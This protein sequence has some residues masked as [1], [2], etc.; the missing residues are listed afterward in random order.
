ML[1]LSCC[2]VSRGKLQRLTHCS[3]CSE[4][5]TEITIRVPDQMA[6]L[7]KQWA[8]YVPGMEIVEEEEYMDEAD[9]NL[10]FK[11]AIIEL[12]EDDIISQ[13]R[14]YAWIMAALEGGIIE[15]FCGFN[16][17]QA[18]IRYME[19]LGLE[20]LP[21]RSTLF[22]AYQLIIGEYPKWEFTDTDK[23]EEVLRRNMVVVRFKSA[24]L[25]AKRGLCNKK[26]T[27]S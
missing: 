24:Y 10:C 22:R 25:R 14:D 11:Q 2:E 5:M 26:C 15:D 8:Q 18:F 23:E 6:A 12:K 9:C 4:K 3:Q 27:N 19:L 13:K 7:V 20:D 16:S 17:N 21:D 1:N